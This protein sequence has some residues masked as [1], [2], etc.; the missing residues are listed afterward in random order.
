MHTPVLLTEA[1]AHLAPKEGGVYIDGT[2]GA[3]GYSR[4]LLSA[5]LCHVLAF[6]RDPCVHPYVQALTE[7]FGDRFRFYETRFSEIQEILIR[8]KITQVDG[9]VFDLGVSAMQIDVPDR[10]F[11]FQ[12]NGLLDMRMGQCDLSAADIVNTFDEKTL[13]NILWMYGE[14]SKSRAIARKIVEA[15]QKDPIQTTWALQKIVAS[16]LK[17]KTVKDPAM[18]TFQ[19][20]RIF[21]ND[22]YDELLKALAC[23]ELCIKIGGCLA[24]VSFHSL[25]DRLVKNFLKGPEAKRDPIY[26][27]YLSFYPPFKMHNKK[28]IVASSDEILSNPRARSAKLRVG[29]KQ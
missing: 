21:V 13:A 18:R 14:E 19:A 24:V 3:G 5:C 17:R 16:V 26:G 8:E 28:P 15:R 23:A 4:A 9:M 27:R 10:G 6:D 2:F 29:I 11:S 1:L 25:E 12:K 22:E 20:L 7:Q